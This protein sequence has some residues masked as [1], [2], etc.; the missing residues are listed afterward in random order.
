VDGRFGG[1]RWSAPQQAV[2]AQV[3][4]DIG[5]MD[6]MAAAGDFPP[7]PLFRHSVEQARVPCQGDGDGV[8]I[9]EIDCQAVVINRN[10][11]H[12]L[13]SFGRRNSH[14]MPP[15]AVSDGH[16]PDAA[17]LPTLL[18]RSPYYALK[19]PSPPNEQLSSEKQRFRTIQA[20][21]LRREAFDKDKLIDVVSMRQFQPIL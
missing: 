10:C 1:L 17:V 6:T 5:P 19:I 9:H 3:F 11:L 15:L 4:I 8:A 14:A 20:L 18:L 21:Q 2:G 12:T 7:L 13:V 16:E